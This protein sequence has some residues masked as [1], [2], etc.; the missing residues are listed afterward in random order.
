MNNNDLAPI[1]LFVYNRPWH[2]EQTLKAL[3]INEFAAE[4]ILYIFADGPKTQA[5]E[6]QLNNITEVRRIIRSKQW[7]KEVII[8]EFDENSGLA[9]SVINGVTHVINKYNKVIVLEDDLVTSKFFLRFMNESLNFYEHDSRIF[10]IGGYN[11]PFQIPNR[12]K[13]DVYIVHRTE[14]WGWGTWL[15]RWNNADWNQND[16]NEFLSDQKEIKKFNR[17]GDDLTKLLQLQIK[18]QIDSWAIRW[19]YCHY[20]NDTYCLRPVKSFVNNI[21]FD[22]SGVHCNNQSGEL[23]FDYLYDKVYYEIKLIKGIKPNKKVEKRFKRFFGIDAKFFIRFL[24]K[25]KRMMKKLWT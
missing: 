3:N 19:D 2:T 21:G 11:Y 4:S 8:T 5:T 7:C 18:G 9:N 6:E 22:G 23:H 10:S 13:K 15:D 1:I 24:I 14:T 17:G 12:Y 25:I 16:W 20:R